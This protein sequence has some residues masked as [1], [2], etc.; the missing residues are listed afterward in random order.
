MKQA[1]AAM[2]LVA[3]AAIAAAAAGTT[4]RAEDDL[5]IVKKAVASPA[6][7]RGQATAMAAR[8][9]PTAAVQGATASQGAPARVPEARPLPRTGR[10]P[11]W[12]KV[13]VVDRASGRKKVTVNLPLT[14]VRALG[15]DT[16]EWGCGDRQAGCR[17][18][19]LSEVLRSL[20][21]GQEL[22]EIEDEDASVKVWVE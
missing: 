19:R 20:E 11:K 8:A 15:D 5:A 13:R 7:A 4:A 3:A 22:V 14:L 21:A 9:R 1:R 6:P 2:V 17:T 10:E 16:V 18:I 12:F